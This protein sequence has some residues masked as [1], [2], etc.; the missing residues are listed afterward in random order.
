MFPKGRR[1]FPVTNLDPRQAA[2]NAQS[3]GARGEGDLSGETKSLSDFRD[4]PHEY[5][6]QADVRPVSKA[7]LAGLPPPCQ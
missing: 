1:I 4:A 2:E 7:V 5:E 3:E 6:K